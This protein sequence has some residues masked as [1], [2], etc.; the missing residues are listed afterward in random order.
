MTENKDLQCIEKVLNGNRQAY[1]FLVDKYKDR[2]F[3]LALKICTSY[4]DAEE[5]AQDAFV[6][7]FTSLNSFK[8]KSSFSTW[9]YRITYN[10]AITMVRKRD[11]RVLQIEDFPVDSADFLRDGFDEEAAEKEYR[12]ALLNFAL[13]KLNS[14]DRAI[15]SLFY[16][17]DATIEEIAKVIETS[18]S[19]VKV[20]LHRTRKKLS[21]IIGKNSNYKIEDHE[22]VRE[23][24]G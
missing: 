17:Q 16:Y 6:K 13:Q 10:T 23:I 11:N 24:Q 18:T 4:E 2:I 9:L 15:V 21:E 5:V 7:A 12:L 8:R 14:T 3:S 19:N 1:S 20:R 22:E